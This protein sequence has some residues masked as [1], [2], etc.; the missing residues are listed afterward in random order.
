[1]ERH[2]SDSYFPCLLLFAV[3]SGAADWLISLLILGCIFLHLHSLDM[4]HYQFYLFRYWIVLPLN[5]LELWD[6]M[7]LLGLSVMFLALAFYICVVDQQCVYSLGWIY[8]LYWGRIILNMQRMLPILWGFK[9]WLLGPG[10]IPHEPCVAFPVI[11]LAGGLFPWHRV[12]SSCPDLI[13][14]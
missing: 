2:H 12:V 6:M 1:M 5:I 10:T 13:T 3:I 7:K 4:G 11:I 9:F 14:T 8:L